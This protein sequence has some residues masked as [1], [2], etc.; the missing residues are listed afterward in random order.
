VVDA[1]GKPTSH[2]SV[3]CYPDGSAKRGWKIGDPIMPQT[4]WS[5][6]DN[7]GGINGAYRFKHR[8]MG[9]WKFADTDR[10]A[11]IHTS[12]RTNGDNR[13]CTPTQAAPKGSGAHSASAAHAQG[14]LDPIIS[15]RS[16]DP[17]RRTAHWHATT[18]LGYVAHDD[19][20]L[21]TNTMRFVARSS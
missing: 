15:P 19:A 13:T 2:P 5:Y 14:S 9:T 7:D 6:N 1:N 21:L 10:L 17:S 18:P 20:T 16:L 12:R 4:W 8:T 3:A 11:L